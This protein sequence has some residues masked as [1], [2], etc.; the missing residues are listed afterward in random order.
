MWHAYIG[1]Y[2]QEKFLIDGNSNYLD[3]ALKMRINI[4]FH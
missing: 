2:I 4:E 1:K 3:S